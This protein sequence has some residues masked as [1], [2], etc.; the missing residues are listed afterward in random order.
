H[1]HELRRRADARQR[2]PPQRRTAAFAVV[3]NERGRETDREHREERGRRRVNMSCYCGNT[4]EHT[5]CILC[6]EPMS[7][8][9]VEEKVT[10]FI[11]NFHRKPTP[12]EINQ[13]CVCDDCYRRGIRI[14]ASMN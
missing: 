8:T 13:G 2:V 6:D 9:P 3:L 14:L 10:E 5:H 7:V 12:E 1:L 4:S 11:M